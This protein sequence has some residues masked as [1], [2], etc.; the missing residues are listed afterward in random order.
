MLVRASVAALFVALLADACFF[1]EETPKGATILCADDRACPSTQKCDTFRHQCI[2]PHAP[3]DDTA[4]KLIDATF[5]PPFAKD[6]DVVELTLQSS[7]PF[8]DTAPAL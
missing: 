8:A 2:D 3:P 4:P 7:E 6:G 5:A 1:S